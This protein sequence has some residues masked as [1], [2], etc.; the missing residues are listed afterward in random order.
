MSK[1]CSAHEISSTV[2]RLSRFDGES[3]LELGHI[4]ISCFVEYFL[5]LCFDRLEHR[6]VSAEKNCGGDEKGCKP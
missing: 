5:V 3:I 4:R 6:E 2:S 1:D